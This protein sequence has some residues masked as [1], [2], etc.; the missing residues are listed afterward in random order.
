MPVENQRDIYN[1]IKDTHIFLSL[2]AVSNWGF[3]F[4]NDKIK[5]DNPVSESSP[6]MSPR[7]AHIFTNQNGTFGEMARW[8]V[9]NHSLSEML[10]TTL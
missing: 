1:M 6:M 4:C 2:A 9:E 5:F 10:N 8:M 3:E 7:T